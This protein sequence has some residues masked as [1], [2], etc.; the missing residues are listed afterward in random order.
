MTHYELPPPNEDAFAIS[1]LR[2][3]HD[4]YEAERE[5]YSKALFVYY[6]NLSKDQNV[7]H[8]PDWRPA[9]DRNAHFQVYNFLPGLAEHKEP[10]RRIKEAAGSHW[11]MHLHLIHRCWDPEQFQETILVYP[12]AIQA[13][14]ECVTSRSY[15][16]GSESAFRTIKTAV[17]DC[18]VGPYQDLWRNSQQV[19]QS[20]LTTKSPQVQAALL[21]NYPEKSLDLEVRWQ[22][23]LASIHQGAILIAK[24]LVASVTDPRLADELTW[25][26]RFLDHVNFQENVQSIRYQQM[27]DSFRSNPFN[28]SSGFAQELLAPAKVRPEFLRPLTREELSS[29]KYEQLADGQSSPAAADTNCTAYSA[30]NPASNQPRTFGSVQFGSSGSGSGSVAVFFK[31][32][33]QRPVDQAI[34]AGDAASNTS[35]AAGDQA[36]SE[37]RGTPGE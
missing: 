23:A 20:E 8:P 19:W 34:S 24:W 36:G 14:Y 3:G 11:G 7:P 27:L 35:T 6:H 2:L 1:D 33:K 22:A 25:A 31:P 28:H 10:L 26:K 9:F 37:D 17:L 15:D 21:H 4:S 12:P 18:F 16:S 5:A 13:V 30:S 29:G 32:I